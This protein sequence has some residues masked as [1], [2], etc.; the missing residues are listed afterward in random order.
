MAHDIFI[1]YAS[2]DEIIANRVCAGLE[3]AGLKCWFAPRNIPAGRTWGKEII[4]A[5]NAS[6][7]MVVIFSS[8]SNNSPHVMR[9][10]ERAVAKGIPLIPFRI[11]NVLPSEAM[12]Y[13]FSTTQWLDA[14][15]PPLEAHI[16]RLAK[17]T[18]GLP[19]PPLK[20]LSPID[21]SKAYLARLFRDTRFLAAAAVGIVGFVG[22]MGWGLVNTQFSPAKTDTPLAMP[23]AAVTN[24]ST[25]ATVTDTPS[26]TSSPT[27]PP[28]VSLSPTP[29]IPA[30]VEV[31]LDV[32]ARMDAHFD[33]GKTKFEV[34]RDAVLDMLDV[35]EGKEI[36][37]AV[38]VVHQS[39]ADPCQVSPDNS[40]L[41]DFT[42]D[43]DLIRQELQNL[44]PV[45]A[46][47]APFVGVLNV[48]ANHL[49]V[50]GSSS[51]TLF[52]FTGGDDTCGD[53]VEGFFEFF[54]I[55]STGSVRLKPFLIVLGSEQ[56]PP[57]VDR[58]NVSLAYAETAK[59]VRDS[60]KTFSNS[61]PATVTPPPAD[62][63]T[64]ERIAAATAEPPATSGAATSGLA[65]TLPLAATPTKKFTPSP[66]RTS[67]LLLTPTPTFVATSAGATPS[68]PFPTSVFTATF[69]APPATTSAPATTT[70]TRTP[71]Y[72]RTHTATYT[73]SA[74]PTH[75][76]TLTPTTPA[77]CAWVDPKSVKP[78]DNVVWHFS[79][80]GDYEAACLGS[81]DIWV[82][83]GPTGGD[84]LW[85]QSSDACGTD[86]RTPK[87]NGRWEVHITV[88]A[89]NDTGS[90]DIVL[91]KANAAASATIGQALRDG[92]PNPTYPGIRRDELSATGAVWQQTIQVNRISGTATPAV[93]SNASLPGTVTISNAVINQTPAPI[94]NGASMPQ[95]FALSG[96]YSGITGTIWVLVYPPNGRFYMQSNNACGSPP[97]H[98][99]QDSGSWWVNVQL[100][101][102]SDI[103]KPFH[104]LVIVADA[105]ANSYLEAK[106]QEGCSTDFPGL[107]FIELPQGIDEKGRVG[108]IVRQ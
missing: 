67:A 61:L 15:P 102:A 63:A 21:K 32:S 107:L 94:S 55:G 86:Y 90:F 28:T 22:V 78:G 34:A 42:H 35:F 84:R 57:W 3:K 31:V 97:V 73:S 10:I 62:A 103:G 41:V 43:H 83:V 74:T 53:S 64:P 45:T 79:I 29:P 69:T 80:W 7:L 46:S 58:L 27:P 19:P 50:G 89:V 39:S 72:T 5:I 85:P 23:L 26:P 70:P 101:Q 100:G 77:S 82:L 105:S 44:Q 93:V 49:A 99:V 75:T 25:M 2:K 33:S 12:E 4:N 65:T 92:C 106:Q 87:I 37:V 81:D 52:V 30:M 11:E 108:P 36:A 95:N 8:H 96:S 18:R 14:F 16:D 1:S 20:P 47:D 98:V 40:L 48:S 54:S 71:T 24:Q 38:R 56:R 66:T 104:I 17:T 88:G 9:E 76:P 68:T 59:Q 6:R 51:Q 13:F 60:A 91:Y